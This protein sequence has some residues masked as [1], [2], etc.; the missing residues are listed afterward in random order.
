[1]H[2]QHQEGGPVATRPDYILPRAAR[3]GCWILGGLLFY[4]LFTRQ[5]LCQLAIRSREEMSFFSAWTTLG[6]WVWENPGKIINVAYDTFPSSM[7]NATISAVV[8]GMPLLI[9]AIGRKRRLLGL[10]LFLSVPLAW[11]MAFFVQFGI[12]FVDIDKPVNFHIDEGR[13]SWLFHN[14]YFA[15]AD[16]ERVL[17]F[18]LP[19]FGYPFLFAGILF[20]FLHWFVYHR[21][22]HRAQSGLDSAGS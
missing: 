10:L 2:R 1:M 22:S 12:G 4:A 6:Q 20:Y 15:N 9:L 11:F 16:L 13:Q 17:G 19:F 3:V 18:T 7:I 21:K 8:G 14:S 5:L